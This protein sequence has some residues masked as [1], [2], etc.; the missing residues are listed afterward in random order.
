MMSTMKPL[1]RKREM[2]KY[3]NPEARELCWKLLNSFVKPE[4]LNEEEFDKW[5]KK[6]K[7]V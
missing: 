6:N 1:K 5:F 7:K 3:T 4:D 2:Y